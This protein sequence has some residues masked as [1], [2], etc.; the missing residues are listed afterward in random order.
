MAADG[1]VA[2]RDLRSSSAVAKQALVLRRISLA[3]G[4][5]RFSRSS[6]LIRSRSSVLGPARR[7]YSR[8]ALRSRFLM[9]SPEQPILAAIDWI[10]AHCEACS[11]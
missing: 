2:A 10:A 7:P 3:L 1:G 8:S 9:I 4:S 5:S 11:P 6:I